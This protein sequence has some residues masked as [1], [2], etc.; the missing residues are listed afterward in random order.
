MKVTEKPPSGPS[1]VCRPAPSARLS[2]KP[3]AGTPGS[4]CATIESQPTGE[5]VTADGVPAA[6]LPGAWTPEAIRPFLLTSAVV[7]ALFAAAGL[8][9]ERRK[10]RR[11]EP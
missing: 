1:P 5:A 9:G 11:L 3:S 7:A 6:V 10:A 8:A 2:K 4:A